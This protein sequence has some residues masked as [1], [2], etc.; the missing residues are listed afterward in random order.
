VSWSRILFRDYW[1]FVLVLLNFAAIVT[2]AGIPL[3]LLLVPLLVW[4]LRTIRRILHSR[5]EALGVVVKKR[6]GRG[7]WKL[8][9]G[10]RHGDTVVSCRTY[11][12]GFSLPVEEG[13]AVA[14]RFDPAEPSR[15]FLPILYQS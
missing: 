5:S 4:R 8:I 14:V 10:F 15:A 9:Y 11:V 3:L 1:C 12:L 6:F 2:V 7:E 13:Q